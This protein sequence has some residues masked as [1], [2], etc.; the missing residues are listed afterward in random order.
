MASAACSQPVGGQ[1]PGGGRDAGLKLLHGQKLA[2]HA[3][4]RNV[5]CIGLDA[6]FPCRDLRRG[7]R[8]GQTLFSGAG[9]GTAAVGHDDLALARLHLCGIRAARRRLSPGSS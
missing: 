3:G 1:Q 8:I 2:D 4:R 9:I 6:Q 7:A 5:H